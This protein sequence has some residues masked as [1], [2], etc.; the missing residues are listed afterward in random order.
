MI[1]GVTAA[2]EEISN[3]NISFSI[4]GETPLVHASW[5]AQKNAKDYV[6]T[7]R[8]EMDCLPNEVQHVT[9][10]AWLVAPLKHKDDSLESVNGTTYIF[11]LRVN[12]LLSNSTIFKPK[13]DE[14][15]IVVS[16]GKKLIN[17]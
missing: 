13:A 4:D 14:Q 10:T 7:Y 12:S 6:I 2:R 16:Y 15:R 17:Y 3:F 9:N 11:N 8:R 5:D 1:L